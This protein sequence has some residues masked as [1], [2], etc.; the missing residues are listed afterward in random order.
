MLK[1]DDLFNYLITKKELSVYH[2]DKIMDDIIKLQELLSP[3]GIVKEFTDLHV[4]TD[5]SLILVLMW[6][7][8]LFAIKH[9]QECSRQL[10]IDLL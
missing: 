8:E 4:L 9:F 1:T 3:M 7:H 5:K 2:R 6:Q 10:P